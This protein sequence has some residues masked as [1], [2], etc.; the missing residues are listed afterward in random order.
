MPALICQIPIYG[1][2]TMPVHFF[3]SWKLLPIFV[4]GNSNNIADTL[5]FTAVLLLDVMLPHIDMLFE[6]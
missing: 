2:L 3:F 6:S 4:N 1:D 5:C